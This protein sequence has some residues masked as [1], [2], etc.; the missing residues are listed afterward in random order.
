MKNRIIPGAL[1]TL[2]PRWQ[3]HPFAL[4]LVRA[5]VRRHLTRHLTDHGFTAPENLRLH[6]H[7]TPY[8][9]IIHAAY[10]TRDDLD[11]HFT[12]TGDPR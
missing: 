12:T 4:P 11:A 9:A 3:G 10:T 8:A 6:I 7:T 2:A 5:R 1:V